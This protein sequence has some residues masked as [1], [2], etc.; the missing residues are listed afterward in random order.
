MFT[1]TCSR[2]GLA[3]IPMHNFV[4]GFGFATILSLIVWQ[5]EGVWTNSLIDNALTCFK[6]YVSTLSPPTRAPS[7]STGER[8]PQGYSHHRHASIHMSKHAR[9]RAHIP[10]LFASARSVRAPSCRLASLRLDS[11]HP[12]S[13]RL[14]FSL[15]WAAPR[16]TASPHIAPP[17]P[18]PGLAYPRFAFSRPA[19]PL[20][21]S[22]RLASVRVASP[23]LVLCRLPPCHGSARLT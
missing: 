20:L 22:P 7:L 4:C 17:Q 14:R 21:A 3:S 10:V 12:A 2:S 11:P 6:T 19:S 15:P 18:L 23:H 1:F 9:T 13:S 5:A 8:T 16:L